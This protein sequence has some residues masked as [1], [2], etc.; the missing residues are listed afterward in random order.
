[1]R[2]SYYNITMPS[3]S[4]S[5]FSNKMT[6]SYTRSLIDPITLG[7]GTGAISQQEA[8]NIDNTFINVL[9]VIET[10]YGSNMANK[11]YEQIPNNYDQYALLLKAVRDQQ[12]I[13]T[14]TDLALLYKIA[15]E[16]LVGA[17]NSYTIY[18]ENALLRVDKATLEKR[19][20]DLI[21]QVNVTN[22]ANPTSTSSMGI[23]QTVKLA[24]VYN[25]YIM[26]YGMPESGV[27]FDPVKITFLVDIL[28]N[29][30]INPY[31]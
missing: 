8:F 11:T 19:V 18:G 16:T 4:K 12:A 21:S 14:N 23:T 26:L 3:A 10:M 13:T 30:G 6:L 2:T 28:N 17:V 25:Y 31:G 27:G 22:I 9:K 1:M 7:S 5:F 15:E 20:Q 24:A 29:N